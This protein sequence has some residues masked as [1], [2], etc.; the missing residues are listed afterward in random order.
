MSVLGAFFPPAFTWRVLSHT[1]GTSHSREVTQS[2]EQ[3][4]IPSLLALGGLRRTSPCSGH[5]ASHHSPLCSTIP[6]HTCSPP[7]KTLWKGKEPK[8]KACDCWALKMMDEEQ[9]CSH[10]ILQAAPTAASLLHRQ[11]LPLFS[12]CF[13]GL[14]TISPLPFLTHRSA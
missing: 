3:R 2:M 9:Y 4:V 7:A 5:H 8:K 11:L 13:M 1:R 6:T 10:G 14:T 12:P